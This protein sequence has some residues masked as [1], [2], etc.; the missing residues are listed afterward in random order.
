MYYIMY[1]LPLLLRQVCSS[2]AADL[3]YELLDTVV[4][5]GLKEGL[6][7]HRLGLLSPGLVKGL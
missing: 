6:R 7:E 1:L 4:S 2:Q 3:A 5:Q